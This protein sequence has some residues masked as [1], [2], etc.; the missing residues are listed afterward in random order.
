MVIT[1]HTP[2]AVPCPPPTNCSRK[3]CKFVL[4][5]LLPRPV[6]R[7]MQKQHRAQTRRRDVQSLPASRAGTPVLLFKRRSVHQECSPNSTLVTCSSSPYQEFPDCGETQ[8]KHEHLQAH[9]IKGN[10]IKGT[11]H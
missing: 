7:S 6:L 4:V 9:V 1:T 2:L 11:C 3:E 5:G 8:Y 10:V